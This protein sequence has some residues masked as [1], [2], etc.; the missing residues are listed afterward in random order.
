NTYGKLL[1]LVKAGVDVFRLNFSH[2]THADHLS[3]IQHIQAINEEFNLHIGILTDLQG[4]KLRVGKIQGNA[5]PLRAGDIIT[6][7]NEEVIG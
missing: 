7:V 5:L 1:E 6:L 4:P 2:G 3:V